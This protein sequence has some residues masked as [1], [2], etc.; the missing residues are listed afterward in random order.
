MNKSS[1]YFTG[2]KSLLFLFLKFMINIMNP[3]KTIKAPIKF[4]ILVKLASKRNIPPKINKAPIIIDSFMV[5]IC[6]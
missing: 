5:K 2:L 6:I 1:F 4:K 3:A